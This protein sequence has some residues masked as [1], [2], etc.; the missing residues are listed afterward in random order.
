MRLRPEYDLT[1]NL[2]GLAGVGTGDE[3]FTFPAS[4]IVAETLCSHLWAGFAVPQEVAENYSQ[5]CHA[6]GIDE[7]LSALVGK[8]PPSLPGNGSPSKARV[9]TKHVMISKA[10]CT[11]PAPP[12]FC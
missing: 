11:L 6:I 7:R 2:L 8:D 10:F 12:M 9:R 3:V 5:R 4:F 1:G